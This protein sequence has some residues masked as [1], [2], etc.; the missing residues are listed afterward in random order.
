MRQLQ[1]DPGKIVLLARCQR[2]LIASIVRGEQRIASAK[3]S[4]THTISV[5]K[6]GRLNKEFAQMARARIDDYQAAIEALDW[7][8]YVWRC[9]GDAIAFTYL[10]KFALKQ[11]LFDSAG[12]EKQQAGALSGK[13]GFEAELTLLHELLSKGVPALLTDLTNTIR[14]GDVCVLVGPDPIL[15]EAKLSERLNK[16]GKK[17]VAAIQELHEFFEEDRAADFRGLGEARRRS[18]PIPEVSYLK[19]LNYCLVSA[20]RD[21]SAVATP[22]P[23]LYYV[24]ISDKAIRMED[25]FNDID[26]EGTSIVYLNAIKSSRDWAPYMPFVNSI[27]SW[28]H[29]LAFIKGE[30]AIIV[31]FKWDKVLESSRERGF[32]IEAGEAGSF[33]I[34]QE[35]SGLTL[36]MSAAMFRR[37]VIEFVSPRRIFEMAEQVLVTTGPSKESANGNESGGDRELQ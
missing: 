3:R 20:V 11:V 14:H 36:V 1:A 19:E 21:G 35:S 8:N 17:Q 5:L 26:L 34:K 27:E 32:Q 33:L 22:E 2:I 12:K 30:L 28:R 29:L 9:F 37:A 10:D 18:I 15:I 24:A 13:E 4:M 25:V 23:G 16:R 6:N 31:C 7:A